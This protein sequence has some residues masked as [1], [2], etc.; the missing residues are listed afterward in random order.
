M[1][2]ILKKRLNNIIA[3]DQKAMTTTILKDPSLQDMIVNLNQMQMEAGIGADGN[4]L[5]LY[6]DDPYF[7]SPKAAAAYQAFKKHVSPN[8]SKPEGVM[9]FYIDGTFH[10]TLKAVPIADGVIVRSDSDIAQDIQDKTSNKALGLDK[11]SVGQIIPYCRESFI[12]LTRKAI[13]K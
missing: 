10:S 7:K 5:P 12:T 4:S 2:G 8:Q 1:F 11:D 3:L 9:D 6:A 13:F